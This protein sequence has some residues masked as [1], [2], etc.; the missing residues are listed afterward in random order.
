MGEH[1][2]I[3]AKLVENAAKLGI[4]LRIKVIGY[5]DGT[6]S[7]AANSR[8]AESRAEVAVQA[9][10][11]QGIDPA[12]VSRGN[13]VASAEIAGPNPQLRRVTIE[14]LQ[15]PPVASAPPASE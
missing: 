12:L 2:A 5:T 9:L 1:A 14:L 15:E 10:L 3:V 8:L 6:G 13:S 4:R 11:L 7:S